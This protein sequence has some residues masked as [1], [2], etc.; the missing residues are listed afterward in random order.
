MAFWSTLVPSLALAVFLGL[1]YLLFDYFEVLRGD[2]KPMLAALFAVIGLV[3]FVHRLGKAVLS[4][5]LPEWRL[6][7]VESNAASR[8]LWIMSITA[9]FSGIDFFL[10][11]VYETLDAPLSLTVGE[12][13]IATVL[14]GLLVIASGLVRPF[15]DG[16]GRRGPGRCGCGS[17][18][19][20]WVD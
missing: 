20:R 5:N 18:C 12:A 10:S 19:S 1:T 17:S 9:L 6:I 13:L 15:A 16:D 8:L 11:E 2:V 3:F 7:P 4:P 14:I